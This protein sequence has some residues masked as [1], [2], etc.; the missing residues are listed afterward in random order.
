MGY[1]N[2]GHLLVMLNRGDYWQCGFVI[3]KGGLDV[4]QKRGLPALQSATAET[5][6]FLRD[7][8]QTPER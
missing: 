2:R 4:W 3:P 1:V 5:V 7:R 8:V 6:P